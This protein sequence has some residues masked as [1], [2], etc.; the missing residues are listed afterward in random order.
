[1]KWSK[2][3]IT[4]YAIVEKLSQY[5]IIEKYVHTISIGTQKS[6]GKWSPIYHKLK[7]K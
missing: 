5:L 1:M 4:K 3:K 2:K 7:Q 6:L